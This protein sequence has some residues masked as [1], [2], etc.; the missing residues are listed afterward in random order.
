MLH[1]ALVFFWH[2]EIQKFSFIVFWKTKKYDPFVSAAYFP[3]HG[4]AYRVLHGESCHIL[5]RQP[6]AHPFPVLLSFLLKVKDI[7]KW[8]PHLSHPLSCHLEWQVIAKFN[9][10]AK[11]PGWQFFFCI[12]YLRTSKTVITFFHGLMKGLSQTGYRLTDRHCIVRIQKKYILYVCVCVTHFTCSISEV[13]YL[14]YIEH[15]LDICCFCMFCP[16]N[17]P[18]QKTTEAN[19]DIWEAGTRE[20]WHVF[21][22]NESKRSID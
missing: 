10:L 12:V 6:L 14:V 17:S 3:R 13:V 8:L 15:V 7:W 4:W 2:E 18:N 9:I 21:F 11:S 1:V 22:K 19:V 5:V 20:F 16:T